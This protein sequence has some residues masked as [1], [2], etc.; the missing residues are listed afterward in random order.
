MVG[1]MVWVNLLEIVVNGNRLLS[2]CDKTED[3]PQLGAV[4]IIEVID[5]SRVWDC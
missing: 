1:E 2:Q 4:V 3:M 5:N